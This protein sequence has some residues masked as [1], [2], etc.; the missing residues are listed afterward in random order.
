LQRTNARVPG[1]TIDPDE[2]ME[3]AQRLT[4]LS[5][6]GDRWFER[7]FR[8]LVGFINQEAGLRSAD[9][10]PVQTL[11]GYLVDRLRLVD[12]L[13]RHPAVLAEKLEVGG[14]IIGLPRGGSTL[15]QRLLT[16]S[17]QLTST[18]FWEGITPLPLADEEPGQPVRR[19][20][21]GREAAAA[22]AA[23]WPNMKSM[24]P[25]GAESYEEETALLA[26]AFISMMFIS[27]FHLPSYVSWQFQQDHASAYRELKIWLQVLQYNDPS[28]RGRKWLLKTSCHLLA[29]GLAAALATFPDAKAILSHRPIEQVIASWCSLQYE[30]VQAAAHP[31]D[32]SLLGPEAL[33][34]FTNGFRT[35]TRARS[36]HP[37]RFI[38]VE[39]RDL[40]Q[41]PLGQFRRLM[42]AMGLEP[43]ADD[44]R[45]M[46]AWLSVNGRDTHPAHRYRLEDYGVSADQIRAAL[47]SEAR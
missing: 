18:W 32:R 27:L 8:E 1:A 45:S 10:G 12:Y 30:M 20:E 34:L 19:K 13:D 41:D 21:I 44:E 47:G 38:D 2:M 5:D 40:V 22:M 3:R 43:T 28:R 11:V 37:D 33:E 7:P 35:L 4:G 14:I 16:T 39:Y 31:F 25:I 6:F 46:Q 42:R 24:H 17:S 29:G 15:L 36:Q 26:H 9:V 23:A